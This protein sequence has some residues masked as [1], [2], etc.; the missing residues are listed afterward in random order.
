[1]V[2][3]MN[4][5]EKFT[6]LFYAFPEMKENIMSALIKNNNPVKHI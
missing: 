3:G 5:H 6:N 1:M 2:Q 4:I